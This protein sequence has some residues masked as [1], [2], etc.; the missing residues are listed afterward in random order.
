MLSSPFYRP[1]FIICIFLS[2]FRHAPSS[3]RH[4]RETPSKH[5]E[6]WENSRQLC[7]PETSPRIYITFEN[8]PRTQRLVRF[9]GFALENCGLS[10]CLPRFAAILEFGLWFSVFVNN[11]G[12][13]SDVFF[14]QCIL[15]FF[16][17]CQ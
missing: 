8:S 15:R 2:A 17:F 4:F 7:K 9:F 11:D 13:F 3:R 16:W 1:Y 14:V 12:G 5:E 6:G 10:V